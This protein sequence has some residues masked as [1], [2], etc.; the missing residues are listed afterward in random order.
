LHG[1]RRIALSFAVCPRRSATNGRKARGR[2]NIAPAMCT[3]PNLIR[4]ALPGE[5]SRT[6]VLNAM[7]RCAVLNCAAQQLCE[8]ILSVQDRASCLPESSRRAL[9]A[10]AREIRQYQMHPS[11]PLGS[12]TDTESVALP[13]FSVAGQNHVFS[14]HSFQPTA[15]NETYGAPPASSV[16]SASLCL[17]LLRLTTYNL[18]LRTP[19]RAPCLFLPVVFYL[20]RARGPGSASGQ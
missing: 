6:C 14:A 10:D 11:I 18:Q 1:R 2:H 8:K 17:V 13:S 19:L 5:E 3:A 20:S 15:R 4:I 7:R 12:V 9:V 16:H